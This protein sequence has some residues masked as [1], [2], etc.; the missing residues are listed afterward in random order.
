MVT[1][2]SLG[3][4][5]RPI[6]LRLVFIRS[7]RRLRESFCAFIASVICQA[8]TSLMA[9]ASNSSSLPSSL[10]KESRVVSSSAERAVFLF[11]TRPSL[12]LEFTVTFAR[13]RNVLVRCLL[14]FLDEAMKDQNFAL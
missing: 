14:G 12:P 5:R 4:S 9:T 13:Q 6:W 3:S 11:F 1:F 10:R 8:R 7:A 2:P